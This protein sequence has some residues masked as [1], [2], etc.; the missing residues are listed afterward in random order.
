MEF[1]K[2]QGG[3]SGGA[4]LGALLGG[5][6]GFAKAPDLLKA[7][8]MKNPQF[9]LALQKLMAHSPKKAVLTAALSSALGGALGGAAQ[10]GIL[11]SG[12]GLLYDLFEDD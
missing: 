11:G 7:Q 3:A 2:T 10:G 8:A 6:Y 4:G 12:G 9:A 5:G 1:D